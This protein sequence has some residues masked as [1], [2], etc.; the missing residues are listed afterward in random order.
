M[1]EGVASMNIRLNLPPRS[2]NVTIEHNPPDFGNCVENYMF[3]KFSFNNWV[4]PDDNCIKSYSIFREYT[5][6]TNVHRI[7]A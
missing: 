6:L 1:F 3:W 4:D 2:G 7:G 5:S